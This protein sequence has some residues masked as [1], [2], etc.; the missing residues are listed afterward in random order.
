MESDSKST[1][2]EMKLHE[3]AV[4]DHDDLVKMHKTKEEEKALRGAYSALKGGRVQAFRAMGLLAEY[5]E[6]KTMA[7]AIDNKDYLN[8]PG[9]HQLMV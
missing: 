7:E 6:W 4:K 9:L 8:I 5:L 2:R 1:L 3:Q